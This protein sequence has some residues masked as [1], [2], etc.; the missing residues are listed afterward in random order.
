MDGQRLSPEVF[1]L[2][3]EGLRRG[4]YTD[5][6]F[7][8]IAFILTTLAAEGYRFAGACPTLAAQGVDV[9][10]VAVGDLEVDMQYFTKREPFS[11]VAGVDHALAILRECT[12]YFAADGTFV[13]TA[14]H[15][16]IDALQDGAKVEPW[17]PVLRVRGRYRDFGFLETP[18]LGVLARAT[19][20]ATN[21]YQTV[22]AAR[23]KPILFFPA[24]FDL[25]E[26]QASDGYA[27]HIGVERYNW[28]TGSQSPSLV[29]TDAQ[30]S[31][32]GS[33]GIGTVAH[34]YIVS[35][36]RDTAEAMLHFARLMPPATR[37]IALVDTNNDCVADSLATARAMFA[38]YRALVEAGEEAEAQKYVLYGVRPDTAGNLRD[39]SV[40]PLGDPT[41][42]NGV[43]ARLVT[44]LRRALD[45]E[46]ERLDLPPEWH[47]RA[48]AYFRQIQIIVTGGFNPERIA[49][50]EQ[51]GVPVDSYGVGSYLLRGEN[52][53]YTADVVRVK[54]G[55]VW[56]DLAKVGRGARENPD[57]ERVR[58]EKD[59]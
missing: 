20:I 36:L 18:T 34:A 52:N 25:P 7:N 11:V 48:R 15:L 42:D 8:N 59:Q 54:I 9:S 12:G 27:Y 41:L 16:E 53:D 44:N 58:W 2:D 33:R 28:E 45:E 30:G 14:D 32:W 40:E 43:C 13:N 5:Q 23:G 46:P 38:Q 17:Q 1:K 39:A 26:T 31:W 22:K 19:R 55:G 49:L 57:L 47:D 10:E 51:L 29:S 50:F 37:R 21:V 3:V 6:Y 56:Y 24:R 35:F 4:W